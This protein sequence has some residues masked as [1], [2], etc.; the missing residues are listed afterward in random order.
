[1]L[2]F[3]GLGAMGEP[4]CK[5]LLL[6]GKEKVIAYDL[7]SSPLARLEKEGIK[8]AKC[9]AELCMESDTIFLSLPSGDQVN[10]VCLGSSGLINHLEPKQCVVDC[11]TSPPELACKI[12]ETY[13]MKQIDFADAPVSRTRSAAIKGTLSIT[14]GAQEKIFE[15]IKPFLACMATDITYC[16][17]VGAGQTV[18]I[19]NNMLLFQNCL[20]IAQALAVAR[21]SGLDEKTF[22]DAIAKGSGDSFAL[23]NHAIKSML[24]HN[25]PEGMFSVNYAL[26]DLNYAMGLADLYDIDIASLKIIRELF[27]QTIDRGLG[28]H[29]HPIIRETID[30]Q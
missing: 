25:Y 3:V 28:E 21:K 14:V 24:T 19:L 17:E 29:Y 5:N 18:K 4:M 30:S 2:G 8:V 9:L 12:Q 20:A 23:R 6:N 15:K 27:R 7:K 13:E 1:M 16:G 10:E 11:S 26:K 22:L